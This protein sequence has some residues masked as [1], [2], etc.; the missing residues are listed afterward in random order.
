M[1]V[2]AIAAVLGT[3]HGISYTVGAPA[4]SS[5]LRANYFICARLGCK[6]TV[7]AAA[8]PS[9]MTPRAAGPSVAVPPSLSSAASA[10]MAVSL[11]GLGWSAVVAGLMAF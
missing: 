11:A 9:P 1:V 8:A 5:K 7:E 3:A 6:L 2:F 10:G 4:G